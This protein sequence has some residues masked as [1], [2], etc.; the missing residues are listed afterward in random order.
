MGS[1][2]GY[3]VKTGT[4]KVTSMP[5]MFQKFVCLLVLVLLVLLQ[6]EKKKSKLGKRNESLSPLATLK[7]IHPATTIYFLYSS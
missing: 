4:E 7:K 1:H 6:Q 3:Y 2:Q 5:L